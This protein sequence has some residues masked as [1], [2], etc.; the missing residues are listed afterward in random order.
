MQAETA[1][2]QA[3]VVSLS[4]YRNWKALSLRVRAQCIVHDR[5][6]DSP[7]RR[8]MSPSSRWTR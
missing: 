3:L 6:E 1:F 5:Q 8:S 2:A 7:A 4:F